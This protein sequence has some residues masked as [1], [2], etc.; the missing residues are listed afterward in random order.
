MYAAR[1]DHHCTACGRNRFL[2]FWFK[3]KLPPHVTDTQPDEDRY[4]CNACF[5][6][7]WDLVVPETCS[8]KLHRVFTSPDYPPPY[9]SHRPKAASTKQEAK[10][11]SKDDDKG[12]SD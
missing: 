7:N 8:G 1:V 9:A 5:A 2:K 3:E 10:H 11:E 6:N 4:M 12:K